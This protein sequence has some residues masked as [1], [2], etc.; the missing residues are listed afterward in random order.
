[1]SALNQIRRWQSAARK[2]RLMIAVLIDVP[3]LIALYLV[4]S[5]FFSMP[6][7][8]AVTL[9]SAALLLLYVLRSIEAFDNGWLIRQLDQRLANLEDS[10]D[11][12]FKPVPELSTLQNLQ[13]ERIEQRVSNLT[14]V[15]LRERWLCH[16]HHH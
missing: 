4:V 7:S 3:L 12:L 9:A 10:S 5:R 15:D 8:I 11:L 13:R 1:M 6:I 16:P 2:R 14:N